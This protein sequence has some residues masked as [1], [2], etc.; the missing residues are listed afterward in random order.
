MQKFAREKAI[1]HIKS[2][3]TKRKESRL[4]LPNQYE[5]KRVYDTNHFQ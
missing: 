1:C 3:I 2:T 5:N 4:I